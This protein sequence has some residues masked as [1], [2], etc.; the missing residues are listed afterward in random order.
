PSLVSEQEYIDGVLG[1][2]ESKD[3]ATASAG[4]G[5]QET[6]DDRALSALDTATR[7]AKTYPCD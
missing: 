2:H 5:A 6:F 3:V 7:I 1:Q 4:M